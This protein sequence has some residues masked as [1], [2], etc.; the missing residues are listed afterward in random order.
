MTNQINETPLP[1]GWDEWDWADKKKYLE[2]QYNK[3]ALRE[4]VAGRAEIPDD[5]FGTGAFPKAALAHLVLE[6]GGDDE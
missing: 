5:E 2:D 3:K 6:L 4:E 1:A